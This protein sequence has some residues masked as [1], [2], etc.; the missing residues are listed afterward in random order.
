MRRLIL[1]LFLCASADAWAEQEESV[2]DF[3]FRPLEIY[4][5]KNGTKELVVED[6]NNDGLDDVIFANDGDSRLEIL[7]RKKDAASKEGR[8]P[9]LEETF[10]NR[11]MIVDQSLGAVRLVN[12]NDDNRTDILTFGNTL[13]LQSRIQ[14]KDG[15]FVRPEKIYIENQKDVIAIQAD[16]IDR[17]GMADIVVARRGELEILWND[18]KQPFRRREKLPLSDETCLGL[19]IVDVNGDGDLD[20]LVYF[21]SADVPLKV[22]LGNGRGGFGLEYPMEL[23]P[24]RFTCLLPG[25]SGVAPRLGGV[26]KNGLGIRLYGFSKQTQPVLLQT[27]EI[28]PQM[29]ALTG[30]GKK[31][32]PAWAVADFNSDGYD[33]MLVAAPELSQLHLYSGCREGLKVKPEEIDTLSAV[34]SVDRLAGGDLLVVSRVEK[35]AAIHSAKELSRFPAV[36]KLPG[37]AVVGTCLRGRERMFFVCRG[38]DRNPVLVESGRDG[39]EP[40]SYPIDLKN[41]PDSM[42]ALDLGDDGV[43]IIIFRPYET[44]VMYR[45]VD[46]AVKN[47][48]VADFRALSYTLKKSQVSFCGADDKLLVIS[49]EKTARTFE[50]LDG[51]FLVKRQFNPGN[52]NAQV[53]ASCRY[54]GGDEGTMIYDQESRDLTWY[55][56]DVAEK[57]VKVNLRQVFPELSG[58]VCLKSGKSRILAVIGNKNIGLVVSGSERIILE[59]GAEYMSPS[60][61][62]SIMMIKDVFVG[63]MRPALA[64]IETANRSLELLSVSKDGSDLRKELIFEVFLDAGYTSRSTR[65]SQEPHD[66]ES[67]DLNGDKTGDLVLLIHDKLLIYLGE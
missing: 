54:A 35:T 26:L 16:D 5:F 56:D 30:G 19:E 14:G 49:H 39:V 7:V 27:E 57:P 10:E 3:G 28:V 51:R 32:A 22:R 58:L 2:R 38:E 37:E 66:I 34:D 53:V 45:I 29:I 41:D 6:I 43:G 44:P 52:D 8:L 59:P 24:M 25:G 63:A 55:S 11:G 20:L 23:P 36:V 47:V 13:G 65:Y 42:M 18:R 61:E 1:A 67:G 48:G 60:E 31:G 17:D 21:G 62:P 33:D 40:V 46:G 15:V 4:R 12:L 64:V 9:V 50:W